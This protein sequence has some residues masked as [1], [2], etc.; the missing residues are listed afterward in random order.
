MNGRKNCWHNILV[1]KPTSTFY[2][3]PQACTRLWFLYLHQNPGSKGAVNP[4]SCWNGPQT[5]QK[6]TI[7][8][9][10]SAWLYASVFP[11]Y[12]TVWFRN[13]LILPSLFLEHQKICLALWVKSPTFLISHILKDP[14]SIN[15]NKT[16]EICAS[17]GPV[18]S[19]L[20][21]SFW[22]EVSLSYP[23][24]PQ[25]HRFKRSS[26]CS[27][28]R[29]WDYV[30]TML[31]TPIPFFQYPCKG[32][33]MLLKWFR[34]LCSWATWAPKNIIKFQ[35]WTWGWVGCLGQC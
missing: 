29:S 12:N 23:G 35:L 10:L 14:S 6:M 34:I 8:T 16:S 2:C 7:V 17:S 13:N 22:D 30:Y 21:F 15:R 33:S 31:P 3:P 19:S 4:V 32:K 24:W 5:S 26:C 28:L 25:S 9:P 27:L 18:P 11:K 1:S 20:A